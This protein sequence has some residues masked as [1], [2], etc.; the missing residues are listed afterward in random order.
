MVGLSAAEEEDGYILVQS[1]NNDASVLEGASMSQD[2]VMQRVAW[3]QVTSLM[4]LW[5]YYGRENATPD[6]TII[7]AI[8]VIITT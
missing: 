3:A 4:P 8:N 5:S 7:T 6:G 1:E 2:G